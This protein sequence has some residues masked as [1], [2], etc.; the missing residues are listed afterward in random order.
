VTPGGVRVVWCATSGLAEEAVSAATALL[1][2]DEREH[3]QRLRFHDDARDYAVAHALLRRELSRGSTAAPAAW[4]FNRGA[5]GK[6]Y[7]DGRGAAAPAFSLSHTRGMVACALAPP[8]IA[9]GVDV[10]STQRDLDAVRL[11]ERFFAATEV[12]ALAALPERAR[13]ERFYD[14]WTVKEAV[15]KAVGLALPPALPQVAVTI[16]SDRDIEL[17]RSPDS[18]DGVWQLELFTP[19]R[20]F[21]V[22]VAVLRPSGSPPLTILRTEDHAEDQ[23]SGPTRQ[24]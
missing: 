23:M 18:A 16:L 14:L 11:A 24:V 1:S 6:P 9:V 7:V 19:A 21:R 10:E 8:D 22:A 13:R 4:S 12:A 20:G 15:V 5:H 17:T 3:A 2:P